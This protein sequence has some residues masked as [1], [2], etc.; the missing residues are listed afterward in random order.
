MDTNNIE[1]TIKYIDNKC[2]S[3]MWNNNNFNKSNVTDSYV[4]FRM[5]KNAEYIGTT[6]VDNLKN[7]INYI[8]TNIIDLLPH[9]EKLNIECNTVNDI[10]FTLNHKTIN[11]TEIYEKIK[12]FVQ[13]KS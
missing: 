4:T 13:I 7:E 1:L 8:E 3:Y 10:D 9:T 6:T 2:I 12:N 11:P 5:H